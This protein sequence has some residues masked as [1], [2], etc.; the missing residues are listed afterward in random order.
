MRIHWDAINDFMMGKY[1]HKLLYEPYPQRTVRFFYFLANP[2]DQTYFS[3]E[4]SFYVHYLLLIIS[5][6]FK[7]YIFST[8]AANVILPVVS[9]GASTSLRF[10]KETSCL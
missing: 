6:F 1:F 7:V 8:I 10:Q 4:S 3:K 9:Y 2:S 5:L